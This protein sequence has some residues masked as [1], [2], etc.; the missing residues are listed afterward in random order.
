MN[1][2]LHSLIKQ[3]KHIFWDIAEGKLAN[4]SDSAILER[5]LAFAE[6]NECLALFKIFGIKYSSK[7]FTKI[8]EKKRV[9]ISPK[10]INLFKLHFA[11]NAS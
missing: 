9:N 5:F 2:A 4:L 10:I 1:N 3:N 7:L 8:L 6:W 11:Y